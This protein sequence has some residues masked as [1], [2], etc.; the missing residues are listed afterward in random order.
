MHNLGFSFSTKLST[1]VRIIIFVL[2]RVANV[3]RSTTFNSLAVFIVIVATFVVDGH[4]LYFVREVSEWV[5]IL[6]VPCE[7]GYT[8]VYTG[9]CTAFGINVACTKK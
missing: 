2:G 8:R 5:M 3:D 6:V 4:V 9:S 1:A 7:I